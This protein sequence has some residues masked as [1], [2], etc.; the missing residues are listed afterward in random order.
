METFGEI[1]KQ[2]RKEKSISQQ[3][4]ANLA[5]CNLRTIIRIENNQTQVSHYMIQT[6]NNIFNIDVN[7]YNSILLEY[8]S[9]EN[10]ILCKKARN[11]IIN[12]DFSQ[13]PNL[14]NEFKNKNNLTY[15]FNLWGYYT[16]VVNFLYVENNKSKALDLILECFSLTNVNDFTGVNL[17][18]I[19]IDPYL[20]LLILSCGVLD[21]NGY[22]NISAK[23]TKALFDYFSNNIFCNEYSLYKFDFDFRRKYI[24]IINNYAHICF[25]NNEL[26]KCIDLVDLG[27]AKCKEFE[28]LHAIEYLYCL[29]F[30]SLFL[31]KDYEKSKKSLGNFKLFCEFKNNYSLYEKILNKFSFNLE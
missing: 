5:D 25:E 29:Q 19:Y 20:S 8:G 6:L 15:T 10:Y 4:L 2:L 23:L 12:R 1:L 22:F 26:N 7:N 16:N 28:T 11:I 31:L 24:S 3:E 27:L 21:M 30:Q 9:Y 14:V 13:I 17:D 18:N